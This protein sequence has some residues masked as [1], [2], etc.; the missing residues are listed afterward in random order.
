MSQSDW[1]PG[2]GKYINKRETSLKNWPW[3]WGV[4]GKKEAVTEHGGAFQADERASAETDPE[5]G[6]VWNVWEQP[7][8]QC[9]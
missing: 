9:H 1:A 2:R 3:R 4:S 7:P 6:R 5:V 8:G